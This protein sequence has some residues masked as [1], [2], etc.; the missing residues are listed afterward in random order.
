M[1]PLLESIQI[2]HL[3]NQIRLVKQI[4][5]T[6]SYGIVFPFR[7]DSIMDDKT[8]LKMEEVSQ[9]SQEEQANFFLRAFGRH[10]SPLEVAE[11]AKRFD[12]IS[13]KEKAHEI[14]E[15]QVLK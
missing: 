7:E 10:I 8:R 1:P 4:T 12:A 6:N 15:P 11:I 2:N 14:E 5:R 9:K 13:G 3:K